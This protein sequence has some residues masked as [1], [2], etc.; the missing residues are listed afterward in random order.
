VVAASGW[1]GL[2]VIIAGTLYAATQL[3]RTLDELH[4]LHLD[5]AD[6]AVAYERFRVSRDLHDLLSHS[7]TAVSLRGDLA[8]ALLPTEPAAARAEIDGIV[9]T[10]LQ[11]TRTVTDA[12]R[13]ASLSAALDGAA[14]LL[15]AA[16]IDASIDVDLPGLSSPVE[17]VPSRGWPSVSSS[18]PRACRRSAR[19]DG[20][21]SSSRSP[22]R[23]LSPERRRRTA[24][25]RIRVVARAAIHQRSRRLTITYRATAA[26]LWSR[27][28][29]FRSAV[30]VFLCAIATSGRSRTT[31]STR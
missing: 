2:Y 21:A 31:S 20:S 11:D 7:L 23:L 9:D 25:A 1:F 26:G 18:C 30:H 16:R 4:L 24:Q 27:T 6:Q 29:P 19:T 8:L 10:A 28:S 13:E 14:A 17:D 22:S 5:L 12:R 15:E 3:I